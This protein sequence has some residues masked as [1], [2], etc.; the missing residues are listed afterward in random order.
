MFVSKRRLPRR[1]FLRAA[2]V[3]VALPLLDSMIPAQTPLR[4]AAANPKVRM[5]F[6]DIPHGAVMHLLI[7]P[8]TKPIK[9]LQS[10]KDYTAR[11]ANK[12]LGRAGEPFWQSESYDH[13]I[14]DAAEF[15]R[16]SE[17]IENNPV[18]AGL[19]SSPEEYRWSSAYAGKTAV[20]AALTGRS[21]S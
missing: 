10:T 18:K 21:T 8:V 4:R 1:T 14:R 7:S 20:V 2:G 6:C 9:F 19:V 11:E 15:K 16:I 13:W 12:I 17:Y 3:T 5:G